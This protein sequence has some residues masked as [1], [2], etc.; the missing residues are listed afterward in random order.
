MTPE[1]EASSLRLSAR[2]VAAYLGGCLVLGAGIWGSDHT[3]GVAH[4]VLLVVSG[5]LFLYLVYMAAIYLFVVGIAAW[6]DR[7]D[8]ITG[9]G[10]RAGRIPTAWWVV[11]YW[12]ALGVLGATLFTWM[13]MGVRGEEARWL[14]GSY[15]VSGLVV[16]AVFGKAGWDERR[17]ADA[18]P[19]SSH[20]P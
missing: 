1:P 7:I 3:S 2:I 12:W 19:G 10:H 20:R 15:L 16:A 8:G 17:A 14:I 9:P 18:A 11:L 4:G 13:G 5:L 6:I